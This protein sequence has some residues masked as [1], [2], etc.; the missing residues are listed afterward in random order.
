MKGELEGERKDN[1]KEIVK[2]KVKGKKFLPDMYKTIKLTS[3]YSAIKK[4]NVQQVWP[5][6]NM[7]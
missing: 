5:V 3:I 1:G 2:G 4:P 6:S 7:F